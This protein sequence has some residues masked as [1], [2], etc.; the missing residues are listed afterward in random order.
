[1]KTLNKIQEVQLKYNPTQTSCKKITCSRDAHKIF[2]ELY[3][4]D[5]IQLQETFKVLL[6]N[7]SN[8]VIGVFTLASGGMTSVIVDLRILFATVLKSAATGII[9]SHNHPSGTLIPSTAD[10][11]IYHKIKEIAKI[12][13]ISILD[14]LII[15]TEGYFSFADEGI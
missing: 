15:T 5:T 11:T 12:H 1:M 6:L 8:K 13:E 9:C 2:L 4:L 7:N 14:N 10:K 3:D